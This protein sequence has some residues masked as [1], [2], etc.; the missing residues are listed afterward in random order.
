MNKEKLIEMGVANQS[1]TMQVQRKMHTTPDVRL[2]EVRIDNP[3]DSIN[4]NCMDDTGQ[5][6]EHSIITIQQN[7]Q[8]IFSN[9]FPELVR[10]LKST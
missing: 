2:T 8:Q 5:R 10:V 4:I 7:G 3:E 1:V 9:T 6:Q